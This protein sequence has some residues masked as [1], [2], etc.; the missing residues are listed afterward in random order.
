MKKALERKLESCISK[1][2]CVPCVRYCV[3]CEVIVR[4]SERENVRFL[5]LSLYRKSALY[6]SSVGC[7]I[8]KCVSV[9]KKEVK[10]RKK[11]KLRSLIACV[12]YC[13]VFAFA[14]PAQ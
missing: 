2:L 6:S 1:D 14:K 3:L 7:R 8:L 12:I 11:C 13:S 5:L 4:K 10:E 9:I